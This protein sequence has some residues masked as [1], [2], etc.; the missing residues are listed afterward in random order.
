[1]HA[2][3]RLTIILAALF[4]GAIT[5]HAG[6]VEGVAIGAGAGAVVAGPVGAVAGGVIGYV[7]GGPNIVARPRSY[8]CWRDDRGLRHCARR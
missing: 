1:V 6:K 4:A 7:V 5:A 3:L 8:R 2:T